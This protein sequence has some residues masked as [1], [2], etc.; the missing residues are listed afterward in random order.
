M[1]LGGST[2]G[3]P[4]PVG[5]VRPLYRDDEDGTHAARLKRFRT[6]EIP[7]AARQDL[8]HRLERAARVIGAGWAALLV[9]AGQAAEVLTTLNVPASLHRLL[10]EMRYAA[11][12]M[13]APPQYVVQRAASQGFV[14]VMRPVRTTGEVQGH[15][16]LGFPHTNRPQADFND[17]VAL[18]ADDI[19]AFLESH[20]LSGRMDRVRSHLSLIHRLG[21]MVTSI[22][23]PEQLF[24]KITEQVYASLGFDHV[25]LLLVDERQKRV[26]LVHAAGPLSQNL[27]AAGFSE[28][29]G[30][31]IIGRVAETGHM[32][33]SQDVSQDVHFVSNAL[34]PNTASELALPLRLGPR[35]MGVLDIQSDR[36]EAFRQNDVLLL[37]TVADQIAPVIEQH[38]LLAAERR[39]RELANTLADVSRIIS[40]RLDPRHV[41]EAVLAQLGRVVPYRGCRVTLLGDDGRMRVVAAKGYPDD[42]L[43]RRHSF[44]PAAAPLSRPV[45]NDHQTLII[46]DVRN[47][48]D[49]V[50]QP[51]TGQIV[52]WCSAPL[53]HGKDCIGWLCIDWPEPA[54]FKAEH[55]RVVRAFADQAVVAI[56]NARL[57]ERARE[58]SD[59]LEYKVTDRTR[60]LR[61]AHDE[62]AA[63]ARELQAL[64]RRV[65]DVQERERQRIAYDLHDSAAQSI[66]AATYQLQSIR[67]RLGGDPE[68]DRRLTDCQATLDSSLSEM[69]RIIY[70][71]R[72]NVLDEL[73]LVAALENYVG[74][75]P[76]SA[77]LETSFSVRGVPTALHA[78]AELA[79]FRI[80]QEACQNAVRHAEAR[81][82]TLHLAY[83]GKS[84]DVGIV[85][86]GRGF[87]FDDAKMG[88]GLVGIRERTQ[89]VGGALSVETAPGRGTRVMFSIPL[90][91]GAA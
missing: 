59:I 86:D 58:L 45:L 55:G 57:F 10:A 9:E 13:S 8:V 83:S 88:L 18:V 30:R 69:K 19:S 90:E 29:I 36:P 52:A 15:V 7:A 24:A 54:F 72:P 76:L 12:T 16:L 23:E 32:W 35:V 17:S 91:V 46:D 84:V 43:V 77:A 63:K 31:G 73:G 85:D 42:G 25:Q 78:E 41:L 44:D 33:M 11:G 5:P 71:L 75:L 81:S 53:V 34:L 87:V 38:R 1:G 65:V 14:L 62:I 89:V 51:G 27:L 3:P 79:I 61:E 47:E 20:S 6:V 22:R 68:L 21:Q 28:D 56:E 50:W 26:S 48:A 40:S 64:W 67:R 2:D 74:T 80:V 37:Q 66:M 4:L 39:E 70:A 60:L 49:W 82:L